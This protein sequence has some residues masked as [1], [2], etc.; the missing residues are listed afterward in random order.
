MRTPSVVVGTDGT[1]CGTA[2]VEWAAREA[3]RRQASLRIAHAF[4]WDWNESR[5]TVG[6]DYVDVAQAV[7]EA[8]VS[9]ARARARAVAPGIEIATS[10]L[11]GRAAPRLLEIARGAVMLVVGNRGRG[12]FAGLL[13]GSVGQRMASEAPCPVVI[14]RGRAGP[15]GPVVAGVDDSPAA[16][17]VLG[18]AF[19]AA[20]A[21]GAALTVVRSYLPVI[22]LWLANVRPADVDTPSEDAAE[23]AALDE[24]L[25]PWAAKFPRVGV[26][27][28]VTHE[29]AAA[30]LVAA[31]ATG[32][33]VVVGSHG[34]GPLSGALLGS[35]GQQLLHHAECPVLIARE[36]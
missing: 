9:A 34:R 12:G 5:F 3:G 19:E 1:A 6:T 15:D 20:A 23:R 13:L 10:T 30:A 4:D 17:H 29:S 27:V 31:S 2:A 8:T 24:L 26:E 22:P 14:V 35:A 18:V 16:E 11:I 21:R 25:A 36:R 33:L 32:Q 28:V 7:A